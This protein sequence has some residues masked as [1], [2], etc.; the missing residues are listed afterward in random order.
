MLKTLFDFIYLYFKRE[1]EFFYI[2]VSKYMLD[3]HKFDYNDVV[4]S[5]FVFRI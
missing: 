2:N 5:R 1:N 3:N 4:Y